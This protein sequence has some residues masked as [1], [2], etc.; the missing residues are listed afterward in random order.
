M[1]VRATPRKWPVGT[2]NDVPTRVDGRIPE[3]FVGNSS[4]NSYTYTY[5]S[6]KYELV[7]WDDEISNIWGKNM[8][9]ITNQVYIW[10]APTSHGKKKS[11]VFAPWRQWRL[12][13]FAGISSDGIILKT[14]APIF[15]EES[16]QFFPKGNRWK[17]IKGRRLLKG[18]GT[19][20]HF[21]SSMYSFPEI[22]R[23]SC[24]IWTN[25]LYASNQHY[26]AIGHLSV[27]EGVLDPQILC[28][29]QYFPLLYT[30]KVFAC[31]NYHQENTFYFNITNGQVHDQLRILDPCKNQF[32]AGFYFISQLRKTWPKKTHE[33]DECC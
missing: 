24:S 22:F 2:T 21:P 8:F 26:W 30:L 29:N 31:K 17:P 7:S 11:V 25:P 9:Q 14:T 19:F 6:E 33:N 23:A 4:R 1:A 27:F 13:K 5:P 32:S 10:I 20:M 18:H 15:L 3:Q 16:T 28:W 12:S